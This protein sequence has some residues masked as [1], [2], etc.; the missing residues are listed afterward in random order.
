MI[1]KAV[2]LHGKRW[3]LPDLNGQ[4]RDAHGLIHDMRTGE[5]HRVPLEIDLL[6]SPCWK[7][8]GTECHVATDICECHP[9]QRGVFNLDTQSCEHGEATGAPLLGE[10][11]DC[12]A[13]TGYKI[14]ASGFG[15]MH[16]RRVDEHYNVRTAL[17]AGR[18]HQGMFHRIGRSH[19][20]SA[21]AMAECVGKVPQ[22]PCEMGYFW[23][24][25]PAPEYYH[26]HQCRQ[27]FNFCLVDE[28]TA[29]I[30]DNPLFPARD[31]AVIAAKNSVLDV[32]RN[33]DIVFPD[34][35]DFR[36]L[37]Y[38]GGISPSPNNQ[39][40]YWARGAGVAEGTLCDDPA[41]PVA[42]TFPNSYLKNSRCPVHAELIVIVAQIEMSLVPYKVDW[43]AE[44]PPPAG[45]AER[46]VWPYARVRISAQCGVRATLPN[47][48]CT[49]VRPWIPVGEPGHTVSLG[50]VNPEPGEGL[51]CVALPTVTPNVDQIIYV[52][53]EGRKLNPPLHVEWMGYLGAFSDPPTSEIWEN[54]DSC[55]T[56]ESMTAYCLR[57]ADALSGLTV[58]G[59][60]FFSDSMPNDPNQVYGGHLR[61]DFRN[62]IYWG[63]CEGGA[64]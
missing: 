13:Y 23:V 45:D 3:L 48:E 26:A 57:L 51:G 4:A 55:W 62:S 19:L 63:C 36:Q 39:L 64:P 21:T 9:G 38:F 41:I 30:R 46:K 14:S 52:D 1:F 29:H 35:R 42:T 28:N 59:W 24:Q 43:T 54:A 12:N 47:G 40:D 34:G 25:E 5:P 60:P 50:I 31:R 27:V 56:G 18:L 61:L 44:P 58:P 33:P 2:V 16:C 7:N 22:S 10:L 37:D 20:C 11:H 8:D 6:R 32:I 49:M 17:T 53:V 15:W